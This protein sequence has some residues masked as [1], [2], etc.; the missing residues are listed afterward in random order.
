MMSLFKTLAAST[1]VEDDTAAPV[2]EAAHDDIK[3]KEMSEKS[4]AYT[5]V[6]GFSFL[7]A[8]AFASSVAVIW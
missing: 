2:E 4:S 6:T 5:G 3:E 1:E 7:A 8:V